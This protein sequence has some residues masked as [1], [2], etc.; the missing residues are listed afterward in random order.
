MIVIIAAWSVAFFLAEVFQCRLDPEI[1]WKDRN[2]APEHCS[3]NATKLLLFAITDV[4]GDIAVLVMPYRPISKLHMGKRE[5][6][7]LAGI[8]ALGGL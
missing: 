2:Q 3:D 5:K 8:F 1:T 7:G 4:I 6:W